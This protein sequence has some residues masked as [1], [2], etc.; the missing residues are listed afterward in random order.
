MVGNYF[1]FASV[2]KVVGAQHFWQNSSVRIS[3]RNN[4]FTSRIFE[5]VFFVCFFHPLIDGKQA[6]RQNTRN[7]EL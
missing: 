2:A 4:E 5:R 7:V 1:D 3:S 6:G